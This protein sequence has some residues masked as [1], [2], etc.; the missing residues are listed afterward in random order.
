[1]NVLIIHCNK[2]YAEAATRGA[3]EEKVFLEI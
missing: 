2:A 3:L 1:M